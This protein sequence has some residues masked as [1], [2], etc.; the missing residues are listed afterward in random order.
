[1]TPQKRTPKSEE[2]F[3]TEWRA[4]YGEE[5]AAMIRKTVV[6][7]MPDYL[8]LKHFAMRV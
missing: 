1:V 4:K 8:Y 7:N 2:E 3:D 6:Q 5:A